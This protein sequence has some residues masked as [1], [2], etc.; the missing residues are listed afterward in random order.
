MVEQAALVLFVCDG[1][2]GITQEDREL[3]NLLHKLNKLVV[4]VV[5]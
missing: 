5:N 3:A 4:L 2:V 1:T